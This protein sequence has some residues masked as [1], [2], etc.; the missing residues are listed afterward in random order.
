MRKNVF[1]CIYLIA[2]V[3]LFGFTSC[4]NDDEGGVSGVESLYGT[5]R[6]TRVEGWEYDTPTKRDDLTEDVSE[7]DASYYEFTPYSSENTSNQNGYY[8]EYD[9]EETYVTRKKFSFT[10]GVLKLSNSSGTETFSV[11]TLTSSTLIL[12]E[13]DETCYIKYIYKKVK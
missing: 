8:S 4:S 10:E 13:S 6:L 11:A 2:T 12:V 1:Y 3:L 7:E 5:W 9:N